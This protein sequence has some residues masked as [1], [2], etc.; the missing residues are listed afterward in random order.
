MTILLPHKPLSPR[1]IAAYS[2][3]ALGREFSANCV[4]AFFFAYLCIYRHLNPLVI[5]VAFV[6][7]RVWDAVNDPMLATLVNNAKRRKMGRYR[8]WILGGAV[9]SAAVLRVFMFLV[10]IP[11][12]LAGYLVYK[13]KYRLYGSR[14]EDIKREIDRRRAQGE[15]QSEAQSAGGGPA[16]KEAWIL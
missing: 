4:N 9:A 12:T 16:D 7:A 15:T 3:G 6:F 13:Q 10:P 2:L 5:S 1:E 11:L 8:P 14:Y